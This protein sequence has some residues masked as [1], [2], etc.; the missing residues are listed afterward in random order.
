M[1]GVQTWLSDISLLDTLV[2]WYQCPS[3]N[4]NPCEQ[5][6][7][8]IFSWYKLSGANS[9]LILCSETTRDSREHGPISR[10]NWSALYWGRSWVPPILI[11]SDG[12]WSLHMQRLQQG[13]YGGNVVVHR[14]VFH[15]SKGYVGSISSTVSDFDRQN[16][17][18]GVGGCRQHDIWIRNVANMTYESEMSPTWHTNQKCRQHDIRI[19]K[20]ASMT[21]ESRSRQHYIRIGVI[22]PTWQ[23][24]F[25][26]LRL[27]EGGQNRLSKIELNKSR[28]F[29]TIC[30]KVFTT[31]IITDDEEITLAVTYIYC[32]IYSKH[33]NIISNI[34]WLWRDVI[35][36]SDQNRISSHHDGWDGECGM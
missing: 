18:H 23:L 2:L 31:Y 32:R 9:R 4:L 25:S 19:G 15:D 20:V 1:L 13:A 6:A 27:A 17:C 22:S 16:I 10:S 21:F 8:K 5:I 24:H 30:Y 35:T 29:S 14:H 7:K 3:W 28:T 34:E 11:I 36:H 33:N 26:I 12:R